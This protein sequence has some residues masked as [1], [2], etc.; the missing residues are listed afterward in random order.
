MID[1]FASKY[2]NH[3]YLIFRVLIG[4]VFFMHG[5]QKL[6]GWFGGN[7]VQAFGM[8]WWAGLIEV[9]VGVLLIIGFLTRWTAALGAVE[10][11][12]AWFIMHVPRGWN[13][14]ANGGEA[15]LLFFAAFLAIVAKGAGKWAVD[16]K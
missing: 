6:L 3:L 14:L 9:V 2:G 12:F 11:A 15:A 4:L 8:F 10:M 5:A 1:K 7:A 13:P 16:K